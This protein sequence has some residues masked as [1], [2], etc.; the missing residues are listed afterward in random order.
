MIMKYN[1]KVLSI[2][3]D[4]LEDQNNVEV[5]ILNGEEVLFHRKFGFPSILTEEELRVELNKHL[6]CFKQDEALKVVALEQE[7]KEQNLNQLKDNLVG[8]E[9]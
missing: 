3:K 6:E 7:A 4:G 2:E 5:Q 9:I 1:L 8:K